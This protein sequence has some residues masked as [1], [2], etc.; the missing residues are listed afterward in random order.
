MQEKALFSNLS[1]SV[2]DLLVYDIFN[3]VIYKYL[4]TCRTLKASSHQLHK[5]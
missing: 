5:H 3:I 4:R 1:I 2:K